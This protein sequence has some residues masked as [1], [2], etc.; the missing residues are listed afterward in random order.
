MLRRI[1]VLTL[2]SLAGTALP[3]AAAGDAGVEF[4]E[5]KVRPVLV[6]HCYSCHASTG[7]KQRGGLALDSRPA[8]Q[9]GGDSGTALVP[10]KPDD[11]LLIKAIRYTDPDLRMPPKSK[12]PAAVIADLEKWVALGA[13]DPRTGAVATA[14]RKWT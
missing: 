1:V 9:K 11:S 3:R 4:F 13:P 5:K 8:L 7:K 6:E 14:Q 2:F 12:L 10:G